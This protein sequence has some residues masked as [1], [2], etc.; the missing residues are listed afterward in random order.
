MVD[1]ALRYSKGKTKKLSLPKQGAVVGIGELFALCQMFCTN[2][3]YSK[4]AL[5]SACDARTWAILQTYRRS[6]FSVVTFS[7][8]FLL[9][10]FWIFNFSSQQLLAIISLGSRLCATSD[11]FELKRLVL[12]KIEIWTKWTRSLSSAEILQ[13]VQRDWGNVSNAVRVCVHMCVWACTCSL[14]P[15]QTC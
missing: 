4:R 7:D 3:G 14:A 5:R 1:V 15:M 11:Q 10:F 13:Q 9:P 8:V 6:R 12:D 2:W